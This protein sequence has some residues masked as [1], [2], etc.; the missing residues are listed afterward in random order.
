MALAKG[1]STSEENTNALSRIMAPFKRVLEGVLNVI[2]N[3]A[4]GVLKVVEGFENLAMGA[5]RLMERLPLVGS[6]F[7]QV[8]DENYPQVINLAQS[9]AYSGYEV[10]FPAKKDDPPWISDAMAWWVDAFDYRFNDSD[11]TDAKQWASIEHN[12]SAIQELWK[13]IGGYGSAIAVIEELVKECVKYQSGDYIKVSQLSDDVY[14]LDLDQS[15][16]DKM[17]KG[18]SAYNE[19]NALKDKIVEYKWSTSGANPAACVGNNVIW[20]NED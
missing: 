12:W 4:T 2:Q 3:I 17:D 16:V 13:R 5:S 7:K 19:V 15:A 18:V 1:I 6:A 14:Q 8:N 11:L 9:S 10:P 20:F